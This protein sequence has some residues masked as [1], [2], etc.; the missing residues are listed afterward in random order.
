MLPSATLGLGEAVFTIAMS[1]LF[2]LATT[3]TAVAVLLVRPGTRLVA[4]AVALSAILVPEAVPALTCSTRVRFAIAF[5]ARLLPSLQVM[6]PAAPTAGVVQVQPPGTVMDWKFVFGGVVWV[7]V[8]D[9]A[10]AGPLFV[11]LWV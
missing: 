6:V 11:T 2:A 5:T 10:A 1:A 8:T 7:N 3:T 9:V 4:V